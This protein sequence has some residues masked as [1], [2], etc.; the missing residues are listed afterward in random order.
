[1]D[2]QRNATAG[3][4]MGIKALARMYP[5]ACLEF[6]RESHLTFVNSN[7]RTEDNARTRRATTL[8]IILSR[9]G[10]ASP[11]KSLFVKVVLNVKQFVPVIHMLMLC[12]R[13]TP[14]RSTYNGRSTGEQL[15]F[16]LNFGA[17]SIEQIGVDVSFCHRTINKIGAHSRQYEATHDGSWIWQS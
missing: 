6:H 11:L 10:V 17:I 12:G 3:R 5:A 14:S 13:Q 4:L 16:G 1:M 15:N 9:F 7:S 2:N 8:L